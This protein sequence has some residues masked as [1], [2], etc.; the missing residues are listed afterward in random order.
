MKSGF[1]LQEENVFS[2]VAR[3]LIIIFL[4]AIFHIPSAGQSSPESGGG[5]VSGGAPNFCSLH[6]F[7]P[8]S[9]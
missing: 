5:A 9:L 4:P 1:N 6:N 3:F 7:F 8:D 2:S